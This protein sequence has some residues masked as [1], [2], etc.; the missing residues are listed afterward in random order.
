MTKSKL[1][2]GTDRA[3]SIYRTLRHAIIEQALAPDAKLPEDAIGER[4]GA[5]RTIVRNA[6]ISAA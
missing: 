4:F 2:P 3:R 6:P 1:R 5:R